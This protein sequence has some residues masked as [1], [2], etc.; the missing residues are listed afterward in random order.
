MAKLK[1]F[2]LLGLV[3]LALNVSAKQ[4]PKVTYPILGTTLMAFTGSPINFNAHYP[5]VNST[6]LSTLNNANR[7]TSYQNTIELLLKDQSA[8]NQ[9][10]KVTI[11]ATL[12]YFPIDNPLTAVT[13]AIKLEVNYK[14]GALTKTDI[15]NVY[16]FQNAYK[17]VL[18]ITNI[19]VTADPGTDLALLKVKLMDFIELNVGFQEERVTRIDYNALPNALT[20]C[21]DKTTDELIFSW[22]QVP[23]AE[24][25]ELEYTFADDYND[26]Y[27]TPMPAGNIPFN[28]KENST[29]IRLKDAYYRIPLVFE[30]GYILYR[31]R[32]IGKGGSHLELPVY[33]IWSGAEHGT[34]DTFG[35][36][37]YHNGAHIDDKINWQS[38]SAFAEDGKR[39]DIVNYY[40]GTLRSRQT[41]TGMNLER[42]LPYNQPMILYLL[43]SN[44][45][46]LPGGDKEREVIAGETIYDYQGRPAVNIMPTP[47]NS[48]KLEYLP[49]L[50]ISLVTQAPYNW[51]DF[52]RPNFMCPDTRPLSSFPNTSGIMGAA[53]YYSSNNPNKLGY[54]AFIPNANGFPFTQ[55]SYLQDNTGRIAAQSAPGSTFKFGNGHETRFYYAAPNQEELDRMFGTEVGDAL[56]YTKNA[57]MDANRQVSV[58]YMNPEG[59]TIATAL[60]G[61]TPENMDQLDNQRTNTID[62]SLMSKNV[63]NADDK[64]MITEH[65]FVVTSDNTDYTFNYSINPQMLDTIICS[66]APVCLDCI[67]DIKMTLNNVESCTGVPLVNYTGTIGN[68]LN[69]AGQT[70]LHCDNNSTTGDYPRQFIRTLGIGTYMITKKVTVNQQAGLAYMAA[71]FKDTCRTKWDEI[72]H[73]EL[74]HVDSTKCE[75]SCATCAVPPA[76]TAACDTAYCQPNPNRCDDI[77]TMIQ[78]DVSPGGQYGQFVRR[79][80]GTIDASAYPLSVFNPGNLLPVPVIDFSLFTGTGISTVNDL[81]NNWRP[82]YGEK[83]LYMHPEHCLYG[84]CNSTNINATLDFD[85]Q[86]LSTQYFADA[87]AK[88][89]VTP[90]G[91]LPNSNT[92]PYIQLLNQDPWFANNQNAAYKTALT[93][94]LQHY[95][96]SSI[97]IDELAMQM[98]YCAIHTP[99]QNHQGT[100][101]M[102][103]TGPP[104]NVPDGYFGVHGFGTGPDPALSDLEWTFLRA[105]YLSAKNE[106]LT[107][108][109]SDFA[110]GHNCNSRCI[111]TKA[112]ND[113]A[114]F[115]TH[116]APFSSFHNF[117]PCQSTLHPFVWLLYQDKQSRFSTGIDNIL[118]VMA[119]AGI[120][121]N[122]SGVTNFNDPCQFVQAIAG[123][124]ASLNQQAATSICGDGTGVS[125]CQTQFSTG[126][127]NLIN[128]LITQLTTRPLVTL[129]QAQ[130]PSIISGAGITAAAGGHTGLGDQSSLFFDLTPCINLSIPY[131]NTPT[132][133]TAPLSV[134]CVTNISV[135]SSNS[136]Y[137]FD[138]KVLYPNNVSRIITVQSKCNFLAGCKDTVTRVCAQPSPYVAPLKGYLTDILNFKTAYNTYPTQIQLTTLLPGI[139]QGTAPNGFHNV[140][141]N[142]TGDFVINMAYHAG[143]GSDNICK[144]TLTANAAIGSWDNIKNIIS[145]TPDLSVAQNG[146]THGFIVQV[147][148]GTTT[149]NLQTLSV[150]GTAQC[151]DM[152][153][154]PP[155]V[156][157]CDSLPTL[158]PYPTV[159]NCIKD[160][161]ATAYANASERYNAWVADMKNNLLQR[162]YAKCLKAVETLNMHYDDRQYQYTLYYYDQAGNLAKTVPPAGVKLLDHNQA[163]QVAVYRAAGYTTMLPV[164]HIKTTVYRYNT[165]NA[166][167][168]Q[169]TPDAG[170]TN[171]FY[172][173]LGR[174]AASQNA[175]QAPE[176]SYSYTKYDVLGR[177]VEAGKVKSL[178]I[179]AALTRNFAGWANFIDNSTNRT[180]ITLTRY[181][182]TLSAA[183]NARFTGGQRNLRK[184]VAS[185][186]GFDNKARLDALQYSHATH[187][188]YD[189]E[190]N[191]Y[192]LIQDYPN[193]IIGDRT[194][195]YD[196]D[197]QS[198]KVNQVTY[199]RGALDQFIHKYSY[200][201]ANRLT[202][203]KTSANGLLWETDAEYKYYRH[204]PLA[205]TEMG[206]DKV[207]G[208]DYMYTLQG[209]IKGVNGT[210]ATAET[211]MGQDGIINPVGLAPQQTSGQTYTVGGVAYQLYTGLQQFG[212]NFNGPGYGTMH[213]P[214][215]R[216]AFGYVLDYY[217]GDYAAIQGNSNLDGLNAQTGTVKALYNGNISR[218]YTQI[219]SL[220]NNGFNYTCDQLNRIRSQEAWSL[221]GGS[222]ALLPN[223]AYF[224][225]FGYD[226]DGNIINQYRNGTTATPAMDNLN[227]NYYDAANNTYNPALGIPANATNKLAYVGDLVP[228]ANYPGD[229]DNQQPNNYKYND[230]GNLIADYAEHISHIEWTLQNKIKSITKTTGPSLNFEYDA[231][232]NRVMKE[233]IGGTVAPNVLTFYIRDAIGNIIAAYTYSRSVTGVPPQLQWTEADIFGVGRLGLYRPDVIIPIGNGNSNTSITSADAYYTANRGY[234]NYELSNHL[235]NVLA[236][237]TDR[238]LPVATNAGPITYTADIASGQDYY[239]FGMQMPGRG[240]SSGSYRF[241]FNGKEND[242]EVKGDGDQQNYGLRIYD[243]RLGKFL[244]VDPLTKKYPWYTPYQFAGNKPIQFLD[245][246]GGEENNTTKEKRTDSKNPAD[247][248]I[249]ETAKK[250]KSTPADLIPNNF[251][252]TKLL[253]SGNENKSP[254]KKESERKEKDAQRVE[255]IKMAIET[256][257]SVTTSSEILKIHIPG[258]VGDMIHVLTITIDLIKTSGDGVDGQLQALKTISWDGLSIAADYACPPVSLLMVDAKGI[259]EMATSKE[260]Y[261]SISQQLH[262]VANDPHAS[263]RD[264]EAAKVYDREHGLNQPNGKPINAK[265]EQYDPNR[266]SEHP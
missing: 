90:A 108:S 96:C 223:N 150:K 122:V 159:N 165:L 124:T 198:G 228:D 134:C 161:I 186:L 259:Y 97:P 22:G 255:M 207:Q 128:S 148:S 123:Q 251:S 233:V 224:G 135:N 55:I 12:Q 131:I 265:L 18:T 116:T 84:W 144:I 91:I 34:V 151:W 204:G 65:Q 219:Q 249:A 211:D 58:T 38:T 182:E 114:Q 190:G 100:P 174:I 78:A 33:C 118:N 205:R 71:V 229:I 5:G 145:V 23:N 120:N 217:T 54:N 77:H 137:S 236:T 169:K 112:Y 226:A 19:T 260:M 17:V 240:F 147:L 28:F 8:F 175:V 26:N 242:N 230:I 86:V 98:A 266:F 111:G 61:Q 93:A 140:S 52:D 155:A 258:E 106:V 2:L 160:Q 74:L 36:T 153:Q 257:G 214:V 196:F 129:S 262:K 168:W 79:A 68:L 41:V 215:A 245:L 62:I 40:D 192:K 212:N 247:S 244:S 149:A 162:Y 171:F 203:V 246:D 176:F 225:K 13:K 85:V 158:P 20:A 10:A 69:N 172:D 42:Q 30:R 130:L 107:Q 177:P 47:T 73:D 92:P 254:E 163:L 241:G 6:N 185:V 221:N 253:G 188:S 103:P 179:N 82:E 9:N 248:K 218:M 146:I 99:L 125:S 202:A 222:M 157:L 178:L 209:W 35:N 194:I 1:Q 264:I 193:G 66:G 119:N 109:M 31:L 195:D 63:V 180:E 60:A 173:G 113:W 70:D 133:F 142:T 183:V 115:A 105:L 44:D 46:P 39:S 43:D 263:T 235:G 87:V 16:A 67:Y 121:V 3:F 250:A 83:L 187:Y 232:G 170:E 80:D 201:A 189:I 220:G 252:L 102:N 25:Y 110:D 256:G 136:V 72:L 88:L 27:N 81:V 89:Y 95:G 138:M 45:C 50:N 94:K 184:R 59:K 37:Y 4:Y 210:T 11:T 166:M 238:K 132:S 127:P 167:L 126:F 243:P 208:L 56:R 53:A 227:Y 181:D 101:V 143:A 7:I 32:A 199:Q 51:T 206:T 200:D 239:A 234:K 14:Q 216:D 197:L 213:N 141:L 49:K 48:K 117:L 75:Q 156:T 57:V 164:Q 152:N 64:T 15:S 21:R 24:E 191:V 231:M 29:R 154:C 261:E 139:F 104:C 76:P 237:I